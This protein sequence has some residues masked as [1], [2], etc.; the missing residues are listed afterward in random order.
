[1]KRNEI[2]KKLG[3]ETTKARTKR[4]I[5]HSDI[6]NEA[7]D[8]YAIMHQLLTPSFDVVGIVAGHFEWLA[9][10]LPSMMAAMGIPPEMLKI[11]AANNPATTPRGGSM[12]RS[13]QEGEKL[14]KYAQIDDLPLYHGSAYEIHDIENLPESEGADFIISEALKDDDRPLFISLQGGITDLAIALK[15]E[16]TIADK[17]TAIWIGGSAYPNGGGEFNLSQDILA[18]RIVFES[19][20]ALWQ[21]PS[22]VYKTMEVSLAELVERVAPCGEIGEYLCRQLL[23][24][25]AMMCALPGQTDFPAGE[26]WC[27]GDN[28]TVSV[29]LQSPQ[30]ACWHTE[31]A[32]IIND[33]MSY[34]PNQNG[35]AIRVYD[36]VD[37]RMT[38]EDMYIKLARCYKTAVRD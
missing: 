10:E 11:A 12:E 19:D 23:E 37:T 2:L 27:L 7:D 6:G 5:I 17:L 24:F 14:L 32:P 29:L 38:L 18:A 8:Q 9:R 1:M 21:I 13:Y 22:S 25:N 36:S 15:K 28:P 33:D 26:S 30:R 20:V 35:K 3:Y 34:S 16:P 4:V 31:K